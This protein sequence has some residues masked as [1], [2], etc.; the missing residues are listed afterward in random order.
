MAEGVLVIVVLVFEL[1]RGS[2]GG[3]WCVGECCPS[4]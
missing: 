4:Y 1:L 2:E 3:R